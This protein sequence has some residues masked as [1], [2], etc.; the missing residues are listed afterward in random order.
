MIKKLIT[1]RLF[2]NVGQYIFLHK[3]IFGFMAYYVR[4]W[5]LALYAL[6]TSKKY[7][8]YNIKSCC[9]L[10]FSCVLKHAFIGNLY[11]NVPLFSTWQKF[12]KCTTHWPVGLELYNS[13]H[14]HIKEPT[15]NGEISI[16]VVSMV[17]HIKQIHPTPP[18]PQKKKKINK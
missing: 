2:V 17:T 8:G 12:K 11:R 3:N 14:N 6:I 7:Q 15:Y 16:F 4:C 1:L 18:P 13:V 10:E 9:D 5:N